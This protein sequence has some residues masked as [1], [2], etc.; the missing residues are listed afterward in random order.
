MSPSALIIR[1]ASDSVEAGEHAS[2]QDFS[3]LPGARFLSCQADG[4]GLRFQDLLQSVYQKLWKMA[5]SDPER[6][7]QRGTG[8]TT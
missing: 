3:T 6:G 8:L 4:Y 5:S 7:S 1:D 2:G